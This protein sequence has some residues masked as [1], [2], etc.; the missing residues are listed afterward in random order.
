MNITE[1]IDKKS[2][3]ISLTNG[4]LFYAF[5]GYL[6]GSVPDYQMSTLLMAIKINGMD[7]NEIFDLTEIFLGSGEMLELE[8][9][10]NTVDKHST[11]GVGDKTTLIIGPLAS[12]CGVNIPKMSGRGL[13]HTGGTI[14]KLE[15]IPGFRT[16]LDKKEFIDLVKKNGFAVCS[17]NK[18]LVPMDGVIYALRDVTGTTNSIPLIAVSIMSKKIA[19][20]AQ[21][22]LIDIKV[23]K[24]ALIKNQK[25][26][27]ELSK[28]MVQIGNHYNRNV[29]TMITKMDSPLGV[30]IGNS[31][32]VMEAKEI[33]EGKRVNDLS[34]LCL[35]LASEMVSM[36]K[37][38][39]K[40]M[41]LKEV[42]NALNSGEAYKKFLDFVKSQ[43]GNIDKLAISDKK[44]YILSIK[45]GTIKNIDA[46]RFG[47]LSL[48]LGAGR[49]NKQDKINPKVGIILNKFVG[50][51]VKTGDVL[52]T[53]YVD[54]DYEQSDITTY[55]D[56]R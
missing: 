34:K 42:N 8:D 49:I 13:G 26:E 53:L 24:G 1:I 31:L 40:K 23:G 44:Q 56:I 38:I 47:E 10:P 4:E 18:S 36:G 48:S 6:K 16:N 46:L 14:D 7:Y 29:K 15:S 28:I 25:E 54:K 37:K 20:G 9:I 22:I 27:N 11:G 12:A 2:L 39:S 32:E 51:K 50:D 3:G 52:C 30:A 45:S 5:N 55:F 21:N 43:G 19:C 17:Q 33:L 41:A 35:D